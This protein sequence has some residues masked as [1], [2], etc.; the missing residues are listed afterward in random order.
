MAARRSTRRR[1]S[2]AGPVELASELRMNGAD[3]LRGQLLEALE[4]GNTVEIDGAAVSSADAAALQVLYVFAA[5]AR[6]REL[7]WSWSGVSAPLREACVLLGI[8]SQLD[9]PAQP[10]V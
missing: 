1:S 4:S 5:E 8:E 7:A 6:Q 9:L 10:A 3:A 2:K